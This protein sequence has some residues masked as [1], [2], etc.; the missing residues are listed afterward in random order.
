MTK[1]DEER[2]KRLGQALRQNLLRRK[3]QARGEGAGPSKP[4]EPPA[5]ERD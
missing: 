5:G 4:Q 3:A 1:A 2:Q